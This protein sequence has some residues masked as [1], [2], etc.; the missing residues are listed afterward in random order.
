MSDKAREAFE[1]WRKTQ[2]NYGEQY[3]ND[4]AFK[5]YQAA[6][7]AA[8]AEYLPVIEAAKTLDGFYDA[9]YAHFNERGMRTLSC[10][11]FEMLAEECSLLK[12]VRESNPWG[13]GYITEKIDVLGKALAAPL[14]GGK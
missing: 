3:I 2:A 5:A 1:A 6:T 10:R 11:D 13:S 4:F 14:L 12:T 9:I 8:R 7:E